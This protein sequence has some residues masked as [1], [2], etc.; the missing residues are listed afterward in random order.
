MWLRPERRLEL[1]EGLPELTKRD[2]DLLRRVFE[3]LFVRWHATRLDDDR[4]EFATSREIWAEEAVSVPPDLQDLLPEGVLDEARLIL[5]STLTLANRCV[6]NRGDKPEVSV[7]AAR[8]YL[9]GVVSRAR[10]DWWADEQLG[11]PLREG[12]LLLNDGRVPEQLPPGATPRDFARSA[13]SPDTVKTLEI[14]QRGH[15]IT[16]RP[17]RVSAEL[18][19]RADAPVVPQERGVRL[20]VLR[21]RE[22]RLLFRQGGARHWTPWV[23]GGGAAIPLTVTKPLQVDSDIERLVLEPYPH[24]GRRP[25]WA[26]GFGQDRFGLFADIELGGL[27]HRLRWVPAGSFHMGSPKDEAG[28]WEDEGAQREVTLTR[29]FWLGET[30]VTQEVWKAVMGT[31]PS[32]FKSPDRPVEGVSWDDCQQFFARAESEVSSLRLPSEAEWEYACRGGTEAATYAG[33]LKILGQNN[34]P[35]LDAIAWYG[36]NSGVGFDLAEG[37]DVSRWPDKQYQFEKAGTREVKGKAPNG[38]G[39]YDML[40]NVREWC[41]DWW[42]DSYE[43]SATV[44]PTGPT[45]GSERVMRGFV[46]LP[47]APRACGRSPQGRARRAALATSWAFAWLEVRTERGRVTPGRSGRRPRRKRSAAGRRGRQ[48]GSWQRA[49]AHVS[50]IGP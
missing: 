37:G 47:R 21:V 19:R 2:P 16:L 45:E 6:P 46:G 18:P 49:L 36:G 31:E 25:D 50:L 48:A 15:E 17:L 14:W 12:V 40:G 9:T 44:D 41:G 5:A 43:G 4:F 7:A 10:E 28:R 8:G 29:G 13:S 42:L 27:S 3:L 26:T 11:A 38:W 24:G 39:L 30:P 32:H 22:G 20:G 1:R 23:G 35:V 33:A 34:A